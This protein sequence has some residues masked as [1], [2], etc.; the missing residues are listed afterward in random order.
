[1]T[2]R[3]TLLSVLVTVGLAAS[4]ALA[5]QAQNSFTVRQIDSTRFE[6][7][8]RGGLSNSDAW[9][10]AGDFVIRGL[11]LPRSTPVW[12]ISEP[13]RPSGQGIVFSLSSQ[14]AASTT[15]LVGSGGASASASHGQSLC[16]TM[17]LMRRNR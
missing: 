17:E 13:P 15:G 11:R 2:L 16:Q 5:F 3:S 8:P 4:P 9:C 10:A 7:R 1:M 6:V 12:R 14:G